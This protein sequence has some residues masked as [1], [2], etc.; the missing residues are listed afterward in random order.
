MR[1]VH[2]LSVG[3]MVVAMGSF[4]AQEPLAA[5]AVVAPA[6]TSNKV[7]DAPLAVQDQPAAVQPPVSAEQA[8]AQ[9]VPQDAADTI[10]APAAPQSAAI[11]QPVEKEAAQ[12]SPSV[13][14]TPF[15]EDEVTGI[16]TA[17]LDEPQGNWLF[18][19]MWWQRGEAQYEKVKALVDT[20]MESRM[21]FFAK[22]TEWDKTVFDPF[23]LEIGVGRGVLEELIANAIAQM[24]NERAHDGQLS[25]EER[26]LLAAFETE[27]ATLEQLQKD[28]QK[29]NAI[30]GAID[31][32]ITT[33]INQINA[34]RGFEKQSWQNFKKIGQ[35]L[36][37]K[38]A[39]D[40]YYGMATFWQNINEISNYIQG[41]FLNYFEQLG[42]T[43]KEH[44]AKVTQ[45]MKALKEKGIDFKKQWEALEAK[46]ALA[47]D[48]QE[49]DQGVNASQNKLHEADEHAKS[50]RGFLGTI[51][52]SITSTVSSVV[53][54][55]NN[56]VIAAW[57]FTLGRFFKKTERLE[58]SLP[59]VPAAPEVNPE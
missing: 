24:N 37:D 36:S 2:V 39:R 49:Y 3:C 28:I 27:K 57:D 26:D 16:D 1:L 32:A 29:I 11:S 35:E 17:D 43:A 21:A 42:A 58:P 33:L 38:N 55:I 59:V 45:S 53:H 44:T 13:E 12:P 56:G 8:Q 54:F 5:V 31:D 47:R 4:A 18:K 19:R 46:H 40:L 22:R 30:D 50:E 6:D 23:Y 51:V 14:S 25:Q 48:A 41:P 7:V 10:P 52:H 9:V 15:S 34:A 20:I